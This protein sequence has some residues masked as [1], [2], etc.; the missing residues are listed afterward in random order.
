MFFS[1]KMSKGKRNMLIS[2]FLF[3]EQQENSFSA[4][5]RLK[6]EWSNYEAKNHWE[7]LCEVSCREKYFLFL[8]WMEC[9]NRSTIKN[10]MWISRFFCRL[11]PSLCLLLFTI[12]IIPKPSAW[13]MA[14]CYLQHREPHFGDG[15]CSLNEV[16]PFLP[17]SFDRIVH[18]LGMPSSP[19]P[20][21]HLLKLPH[22]HALTFHKAPRISSRKLFSI[23]LTLSRTNLLSTQQLSESIS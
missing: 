6:T 13:I 16:C 22:K 7:A 10:P 8:R 23:F 9:Y 14:F 4:S 20:C 1:I 17:L 11:K 19:P 18:L 21:H 3:R 15:G 2:L 5:S 12:S